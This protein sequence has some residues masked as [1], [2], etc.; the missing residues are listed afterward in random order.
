MGAVIKSAV[1][2]VTK[3]GNYP[4]PLAPRRY[5]GQRSSGVDCTYACESVCVTIGHA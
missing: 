3:D 5:I 1:V 4:I 2:T